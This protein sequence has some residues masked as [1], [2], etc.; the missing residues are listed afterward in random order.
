MKILLGKAVLF[1][2]CDS[3]NAGQFT[4]AVDFE[5]GQLKL[6]FPDHTDIVGIWKGQGSKRKYVIYCIEELFSDTCDN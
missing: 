4:Q 3:V 2:A 6:K 1:E 5:T